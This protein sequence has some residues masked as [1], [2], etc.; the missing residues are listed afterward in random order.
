MVNV[1]KCGTTKESPLKSLSEKVSV[2]GLLRFFIDEPMGAA[3][4]K[5]DPDNFDTYRY[6]LRHLSNYEKYHCECYFFL[7]VQV[8]YWGNFKALFS[9]PKEDFKREPHTKEE[10][11]PLSSGSSE[12]NY[13]S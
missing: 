2:L 5:L 13:N 6:N 11:K 8:D 12:Q 3:F 7:R 1:V 9:S 4:V 10:A